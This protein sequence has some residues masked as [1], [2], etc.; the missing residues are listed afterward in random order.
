ME[1]LGSVYVSIPDFWRCV[2][3][4]VDAGGVCHVNV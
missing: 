2:H 4:C 1:V 3:V